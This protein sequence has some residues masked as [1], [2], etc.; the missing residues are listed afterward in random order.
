MKSAVIWVLA[1]ALPFVPVLAA[2][3]LSNDTGVYTATDGKKCP[4]IGT[5]KSDANKALNRLK[6]RFRFPDE[7]D[8]D[9]NV[10]LAALLAPGDDTNRFD[11]N[12]AATISG[13]VIDVK[14]GG[15]ENCNCQATNHID[16]DTH[17]ELAAH[18]DAPANQRVIVEVTPRLRLLMKGK[19]DW[20]TETLKKT[21]GEGGIKGKWV[22]VTGWLLFDDIHSDGAENTNPG[23]KKNWRATCW[24]LHPV[25]DIKVL[26]GPPAGEP[27]VQPAV[28]AAFHKAHAQHVKRDPKRKAAVDKA[29]TDRHAHFHP[30]ELKE[31]EDELDERKDRVK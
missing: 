31:K 19:V 26:P 4:M 21:T 24:E 1:L 22:E 13:F 5:G 18:K 6:N 8:I 16:M 27:E 30:D 10:T 25:T 29:I 11:T 23:G 7:S 17:I 14:V 12:E 20:T 15:K 28:L 3:E 2:P 9:K